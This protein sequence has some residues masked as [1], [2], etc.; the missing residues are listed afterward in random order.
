ASLS[1]S[2]SSVLLLPHITFISIASS[3][4]SAAAAIFLLALCVFPVFSVS[5]LF[6]YRLF[7][8]FPNLGKAGVEAILNRAVLAR[9]AI[10]IDPGC[11]RHLGRYGSSNL[12]T[13]PLWRRM[14]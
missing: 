10:K 8:L 5:F 4:K 3:A 12:T 14:N 2:F 13:L 6:G 7:V 11:Y 9:V 1:K